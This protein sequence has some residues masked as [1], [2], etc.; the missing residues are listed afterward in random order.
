MDRNHPKEG[1][2]IVGGIEVT[3]RRTPASKL[4]SKP[5]QKHHVFFNDMGFHNH[6]T[7]HVLTLFGTG[8]SAVDMQAGYDGNL[9]YQRPALTPTHVSNV[10]VA[11]QLAE[12]FSSV[13]PR[14]VGKGQHYPDFLLYFQRQIEEH[15][16]SGKDGGLAGYVTVLKEHFLSG[17]ETA[18]DL[19]IRLYS[20]LLHPMIQLLYGLEWAQP[21]VVA[22]ALA[23]AAV[24]RAE[25]YKG[26]LLEAER[27]AKERQQQ[28]QQTDGEPPAD[29]LSL[30]HA[31]AA[32]AT[33]TKAATYARDNR[34]HEGILEHAGTEAVA[35]ASRVTVRP[36]EIAER[37]AEML[38]ATVVVTVCAALSRYPPLQ[39]KVDFLLMHHVNCGPIFVTLA[40]AEWMD[41]KT[42]ARL[43]E[44]KIRMDLLEYVA[45]GSPSIDVDKLRAYVPREET[46]R[47]KMP[48]E[49]FKRLHALGADEDGH[50]I[51]L[52]RAIE[53]CRRVCR[54]YKG[55]PWVLLDEDRGDYEAVLRLVV[56]SV[57][58]GGERW[59]SSR[60]L[61]ELWK[62]VPK[63]TRL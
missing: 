2:Q 58:T 21:A 54:P 45:R 6:L 13:A 46:S 47:C 61:D 38:H 40:N 19:L 1:C 28:T 34:I 11:D 8:A 10:A 27:M 35:L 26:F 51:K 52:A 12:D 43:L 32:D 55:R 5:S 42:S 30:Y 33:L 60:R 15:S 4:T 41:S 3:E 56:D 57:E 37:T 24:H 39:P 48:D 14:L 22:Q 36:D 9:S 50:A 53:I 23:Q 49:F 18:D 44:W 63:A 16:S 7:H 29:I 31:A 59:L 25:P 20:G 17:S 62:N